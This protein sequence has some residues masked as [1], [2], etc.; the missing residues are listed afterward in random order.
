V[1]AFD[2]RNSAFLDGTMFVLTGTGDVSGVT[3]YGCMQY[4]G[5][6]VTVF[7]CGLDV[8]DYVVAADGSVVV[9]YGSDVDGLFNAALVIATNAATWGP[10]ATPI[11][12]SGVT[13]TVPAV[14]GFP[15]V[16]KGQLLR[17]LAEGE[18]KSTK[19][20][21]L[22]KEQRVHRVG[23]LLN[24]TI[25]IYFGTDFSNVTQAELR[26]PTTD[27]ILDHAT[28]FSGVHRGVVDDGYDFNGMVCWQISRP[29]P[30]TV[31]A[32]TSFLETSEI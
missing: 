8:G 25:G 1:A 27:I 7:C 19:G 14:I 30:A 24:G 21:G 5:R 10:L 28:M 31:V 18:I 29:F 26:S 3:F 9:P 2:L 15:F 32:I 23:A 22:G 17:P 12:I 6:T 4:V 13:Y 11:V 16:S 20:S